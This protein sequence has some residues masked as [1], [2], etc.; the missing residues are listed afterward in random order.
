M[1][2]IKVPGINSLEQSTGC[3]KA[4]NEIIKCFKEHVSLNESG[5]IVDL[6]ELEEIHLDNKNLELTNKLIYKNALDIFESK[7]KTFFLGGD[8]SISSSL[9]KAFLEHCKIQK[10][11]PCLI[12]FDAFPNCSSLEKKNSNYANNKNWL[13]LLIE[14]GFPEKNILLVGIRNANI[15]ENE[16]LKEKKIRIIGMNQLLENIEEMC[17]IIM[18]FSNK[19]ELYLS[20]DISVVDPVFAIGTNCREIGGLTSR[21]FIYILQRL[22]KIKNLKAIDLVEINPEKDVNNLTI[23]LGAKVLAELM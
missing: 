1:F 20:L 23:N 5:K 8:H 15:E 10:K 21:E 9:G 16:F 12:V 14:K 7:Q 4:G 2:I 22:N 19:K 11:E 18:E 17:E 13:K 6:N 3:E